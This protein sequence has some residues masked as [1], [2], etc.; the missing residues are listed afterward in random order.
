MKGDEYVADVVGCIHDLRRLQQEGQQHQD[1]DEHL[2]AQLIDLERHYPMYDSMAVVTSLKEMLVAADTGV[3]VSHTHHLHHN[4]AIDGVRKTFIPALHAA[5]AAGLASPTAADDVLLNIAV[6]EP[7]GGKKKPKT[8]TTFN[9]DDLDAYEPLETTLS[10]LRANPCDEGALAKLV[11][12]D[13]DDLVDHP[14]WRELLLVVRAALYRAGTRRSRSLALQA[15]LRFAAG[16]TELQAGDAVLNV[17]NFF[18]DTWMPSTIS[19]TAGTLPTTAVVVVVVSDDTRELL[20][21]FA[22]LLA[23]V[24][25]RILQP[26][27]EIESDRLLATICA[28]FAH[29]RVPTVG[30]DGASSSAHQTVPL[31]EAVATCTRERGGFVLAATRRRRPCAVLSH[32]VHSGLLAALGQRL[33]APHQPPADPRVYA[34]S[35]RML[36]GLLQP[37]ASNARLM[38]FCA[39]FACSAE[40]PPALQPYLWGGDREPRDDTR[41]KEAWRT[42]DLMSVGASSLALKSDQGVNRIMS[43]L[44][45]TTSVVDLVLLPPAAGGG[46]VADGESFGWLL[47]CMGQQLVALRATPSAHAHTSNDDNTDAGGPVLELLLRTVAEAHRTLAP[48]TARAVVDACVGYLATATAHAACALCVL[49][50]LDALALAGGES[51]AVAAAARATDVVYAQLA[52]AA[53]DVDGLC[54]ERIFSLWTHVVTTPWSDGVAVDGVASTCATVLVDALA[55]VGATDKDSERATSSPSNVR[56]AAMTLLVALLTH[57]ARCAWWSGRC[58]ERVTGMVPAAAL[59]VSTRLLRLCRDV[60]LGGAVSTPVSCA[61]PPLAPDGD[62]D[63][64]RVQMEEQA[65]AGTPREPDESLPAAAA[66]TS[67]SSSSSSALVEAHALVDVLLAAVATW[68]EP[69]AAAILSAATEAALLDVL[70][71]IEASPGVWEGAVAVPLGADAPLMR[72]LGGLCH[73]SAYPPSAA[74]ALHADCADRVLSLCAAAWEPLRSFGVV[75]GCP[76]P[77]PLPVPPPH[78]SAPAATAAPP[79]SLVPGIAARLLAAADRASGLGGAELEAVGPYVLRL[80]FRCLSCTLVQQAATAETSG[81][82]KDDDNDDDGTVHG[83][84]VL[85]LF[86][87]SLRQHQSPRIVE[88]LE[89]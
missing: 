83:L 31:L 15:H 4:R 35:V 80:L 77:Q 54:V 42:D 73:A 75:N 87:T 58:P 52:G 7:K 63:D 70:R 27:M 43:T 10:V 36:L 51:A 32:A 48:G 89:S 9:F 64:G 47:R 71:L 28:L 2:V 45:G 76:L 46:D 68:G 50:G 22:A 6:A 55:H 82:V 78:A 86:L 38:A 8:Y 12:M 65:P 53:V 23:L 16:L 39:V 26:S 59:A 3:G 72:L 56:A 67:S 25:A 60:H 69:V 84:D 17:L 11:E 88:L 1:D 18:V 30:G 34:L 14:Q 66:P 49:D 61:P 62:G 44:S 29:A 74:A 5:V 79:R 85:G 33:T 57:G 40:V 19:T 13:V 41:F 37:F 81:A 21:A 24:P 20:A